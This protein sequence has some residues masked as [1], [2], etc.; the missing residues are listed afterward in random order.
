MKATERF[1]DRV[2][3]YQ[4]Y[5]PSYPSALVETL[6]EHCS[7]NQESVV[8]D[9]GSGTGKF[10]T[11]LLDKQLH[12]IGVEPNAAMREA[13]EANHHT[14]PYF[15]S[16]AGDSANTGLANNSV[17]LITA[18]QAFHW[19]DLAPTKLEFK[20]IL[21]PGGQVALI[22]NE[23]DTEHPFQKAYDKMLSQY[24]AEYGQVNHRNITDKDLEEFSEGSAIQTFTFVYKQT[25][26]IDGFIGRMCSSSYTPTPDTA[27][28]ELLIEFAK[29]LFSE[30]EKEGVVEFAYSSNLFLFEMS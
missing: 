12:V 23:R 7:L 10:L 22:W 18:A 11:L 16:E 26:N 25:F 5:R 14:S 19:F 17:D 9:I 21:K 29:Q 2:S 8:A 30:Y 28:G 1:S 15:S 4:A 13:A 6:V 20:R 3:N 27:E 24:C